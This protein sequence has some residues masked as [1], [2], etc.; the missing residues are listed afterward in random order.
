M[1]ADN[2]VVR[3]ALQFRA[4]YKRLDNEARPY[5]ICGVKNMTDRADNSRVIDS[6]ANTDQKRSKI[7]DR[8]ML[9]GTTPDIH[10][11]VRRLTLESL[12][13]SG[14]AVLLLSA[15]WS[16]N[17]LLA[18]MFYWIPI[19]AADKNLTFAC[20]VSV[21]IAASYVASMIATILA[22][23]AVLRYR[24]PNWHFRCYS[25]LILSLLCFSYSAY[26]TIFWFGLV[27]YDTLILIGA[28]YS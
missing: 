28:E 21:I 26:R 1:D 20:V 13:F 14:L 17:P 3:V 24:L 16:I 11:R 5:D 15:W 9:P 23:I 7:A 12:A 10:R 4:T 25:V 27:I 2:R 19:L 6:V 8:K 22:A 18:Q